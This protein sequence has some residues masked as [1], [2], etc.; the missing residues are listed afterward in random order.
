MPS[1]LKTFRLLADPNRLRLLLLLEQEE[2]S[3]AELQEILSLGQSTIS[4]H[5]AQ[6][7]AEE[8]VEDRRTG[9]HV[10][11][12]MKPIGIVG[13]LDVLR[14]GAREVPEAG[15][16]A[17]ALRLVLARRRDKVRA[18]F[19][20]LAGKF[21]RHY[22]PGRSWKGLAETLLKLLPP[23]VI[24]DLGA[25]EGMMAQL[26]AQRAERVIAVDSSEKMVEFGAGLARKHGLE[27]LDYRLGDM[28]QLPIEDESVDV[29]FFSQS[30][31]HAPHPERA[32]GEAY[33]I[34]RPGG[35]IAVL[36]LLKH[37]FEEARELYADLWL[38]FSEAELTGLMEGAGFLCCETA[39]VHR[40]EQAPHLQT[41]LAT[42]DKPPARVRN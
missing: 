41:L 16:D 26:L 22:V 18:Y 40:E 36:D 12:R 32:L 42:G 27:N 11:Y 17:A 20:E 34:L 31:H 3:V 33:R 24:A 25:G 29:A 4:T 10:L 7:K 9:K 14:Q 5:L 37:H 13:L 6:L 21:G 1:I 15:L 23:L 35:R 2:L 28:E 19:D 30:L 8:L 38:G 39:I